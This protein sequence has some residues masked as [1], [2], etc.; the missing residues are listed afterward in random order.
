MLVYYGLENFHQNHRQ[1]ADSRDDKQLYGR[2]LNSD[3]LPDMPSI[4]CEDPN[5]NVG[6]VASN[7]R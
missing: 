7:S 3:G 2:Q 1:Y 6:F 4:A 5:N